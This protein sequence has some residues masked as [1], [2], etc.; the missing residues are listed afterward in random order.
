MRYR[1]FSSKHWANSFRAKTE[2]PFPS[3]ERAGEKVGG[4]IDSPDAARR[5]R[6][7]RP[8]RPCQPERPPLHCG[9]SDP[10]RL[11]AGCKLALVSPGAVRPCCQKP[12]LA[13]EGMTGL[14]CGGRI[15]DVRGT[16]SIDSARLQRFPRSRSYTSPIQPTRWGDRQAP[17]A[18][19]RISEVRRN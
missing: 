17:T 16:R 13:C 7:R 19:L 3:C 8:T 11:N 15:K 2:E 4:L 1:L 9:G 10:L 14:R 5:A 6:T 12:V 18:R